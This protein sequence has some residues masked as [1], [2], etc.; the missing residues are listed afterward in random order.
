MFFIWLNC[1]RKFQDPSFARL[2]L[3][4]H[5][6]KQE[7]I[8]EGLHQLMLHLGSDEQVLDHVDPLV[9]FLDSF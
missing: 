1:K 6:L 8:S 2:E 9:T 3:H 7:E 4:V 5:F